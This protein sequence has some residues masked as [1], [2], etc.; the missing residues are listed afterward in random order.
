MTTRHCKPRMFRV[1]AAG[2]LSTAAIASLGAQAT[3][4]TTK[5]ELAASVREHLDRALSDRAS[6]DDKE[7]VRMVF[8]TSGLP[9]VKQVG[10]DAAEDYILLCVHGQP[11]AFIEKVAVAVS[12]VSLRTIPM[13]AR[14]FLIAQLRQKRIEAA[15]REPV[16]LP[17]LRDQI[18]SLYVEDQRVRTEHPS[19]PQLLLPVDARTGVALRAI[20]DKYGVPGSSQVGVEAS[21][22]FAVLVQHQPP[23]LIREVLP[24]LEEQVQLGQA[25]PSDYAMMLDRARASEKRPQRYGE[26][27]E[28]G[29]NGHLEPSP[30]EAPEA[31]DARRASVGLLPMR[32]YRTQIERMY[33]PDFCR[34]ATQTR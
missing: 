21:R 7:W 5:P 31:L 9:T 33:P 26:N 15:V 10:A 18:Q 16:A 25:N 1:L 24:Q 30:I 11:L 32:H 2:V 28:C 4:T 34:N 17:Q 22:N 27:F 14:L 29:S 12:Q 20:I 13:N 23:E 3:A 8:R 19:D 6:E